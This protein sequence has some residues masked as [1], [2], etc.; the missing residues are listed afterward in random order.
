MVK[1]FLKRLANYDSSFSIPRYESE[2]AAGADI[3]ACLKEENDI[4]KV[5][6]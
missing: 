3:R 1:V 6:I 2:Y 5:M 4:V